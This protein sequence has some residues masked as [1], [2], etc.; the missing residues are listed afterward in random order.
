MKPTLQ[1]HSLLTW[2]LW[3]WASGTGEERFAGGCHG[4]E[5]KTGG[6]AGGPSE[7]K[8]SCPLIWLKSMVYGGYNELQCGPPQL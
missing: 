1:I 6:G 8:Q 4:G 7:K 3:F 2:W 5:A